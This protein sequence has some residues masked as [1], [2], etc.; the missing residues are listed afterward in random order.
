MICLGKQITIREVAE[1]AGVSVATA[2]RVLSDSSYPVRPA[3]RQRVREAAE[4]LDYTPNAVAQAL[5]GDVCK[6]IALIIPNLSNPFYLQAVLGAGEALE[7][8]SYSIRF[9]NTMHDPQRERNFI[10]QLYERQVRGVILSSLGEEN[11]EFVNKYIRKGMKF[12]L[13]DQLLPNVDAPA[14]HYDSRAGAVLAVEHLLQQGHTKIAFATTSLVRFTRQEIY[15]GYRE[16]LLNAGITPNP[17]LLYEHTIDKAG[18]GSD[19]ELNVG[20]HIAKAFIDNHCPATAVFCVNDMVA[21]GLIQ[22]L[23]ENGIRVPEDVSVVGYDDIPLA[24]AYVPTLTTV[25]YPAQEMG[26]LA[27]IMLMDALRNEEDSMSLTMRLSPKL[28]VRKS[29][30]PPRHL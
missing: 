14:I 27:G 2:S 13:L 30:C 17:E 18:R 6:D 10:R 4:A 1:L 9:C 8:D 26:R 3:L 19:Y 29:V 23:T 7:K 16:T 28:T 15:A 11:A 5:R 25:H 20:R 24:G 21:I 12:V 22:T